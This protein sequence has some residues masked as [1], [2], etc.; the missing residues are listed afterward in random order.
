MKLK[1]KKILF[2][3]MASIACL[4]TIVTVAT[5]CSKAN[6]KTKSTNDIFKQV[7]PTKE[8]LVDL[9][10]RRKDWANDLQVYFEGGLSKSGKKFERIETLATNASTYYQNNQKIAMTRDSGSLCQDDA[11]Y[12][13]GIAP[14]ISNY[15][16]KTGDV[17][18]VTPHYLS[19]LYNPKLTKGMDLKGVKAETLA[20]ENVGTLFIA[21]F[22]FANY[23]TNFLDKNK[24]GGIVMQSRSSGLPSKTPALFMPNWLFGKNNPHLETD[25]NASAGI[26]DFFV[27]PYD[28]LV[29]TGKTLDRIYDA[30]KFDNV[31]K[32]LINGKTDF[33]TFTDYAKAIVDVVRKNVSNWAKQHSSWKNKYVVMAMPNVMKGARIIDPNF[34]KDD[35]LFLS[36]IF[37]PQPVYFPILYADHNDQ[38]TP[39]LG[40]KFPIPKRHINEVQQYVDNWGWIGGAILSDA[41][42]PDAAKRVGPTLGEAFEGTVDKVIY[43]YNEYLIKGYKPGTAEGEE[44]IK[45]FE[46]NLAN[47]V[48]SLD[49]NTKNSFN[50]TRIL[51]EKPEV[52]KN[53][54]IERKGNIYDANYGFIGQ[55]TMVN[56]LNRWMNGKDS[57]EVDLGIPNFT[58]D[59]VKHL[60]AFKDELN[61]KKI[62]E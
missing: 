47:Y 24:M 50:P 53:F 29:F 56:I 40:V 18:E 8:E 26:T 19:Y 43:S 30:R 35:L 52:G 11:A 4:T 23:K 37:I 22:K 39:G 28:G 34:S 9:I 25:V 54:F 60:R 45:K 61:V 51:K 42:N 59:N 7:L 13:F 5:S 41:S 16:W 46:A 31:N 1:N 20:A 27:D 15:R 36:N 17:E 44:V 14:D 57:P 3:L 32:A 58:K 49:L 62:E 10:K 6:G 12:S 2:V 48:N 55:K 21:D 38:Y 33:K